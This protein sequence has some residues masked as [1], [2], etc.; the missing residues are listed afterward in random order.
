[1]TSLI[2]I[3]VLLINRLAVILSGLLAL[4]NLEFSLY[5][6]VEEY[7]N[8]HDFVKEEIEDV[9]GSEYPEEK[10]LDLLLKKID[11]LLSTERRGENITIKSIAI[12]EDLDR[13]ITYEECDN[14]LRISLKGLTKAITD[15]VLKVDALNTNM[16]ETGV[17]IHP[18]FL[19]SHA[20]VLYDWWTDRSFAIRNVH[21][22]LNSRLC[23]ILYFPAQFIDWSGETHLFEVHSLIVPECGKSEENGKGAEFHTTK[24]GFTPILDDD[25]LLEE[26]KIPT[27][28]MTYRI[29]EIPYVGVRVKEVKN[30]DG[31]EKRFDEAFRSACR[32]D[33]DVFYAA[34]MLCTEKMKSVTGGQSDYLKPL[35]RWARSEGLSVPRLIL[36]PTRWEDESNYLL[37]FDEN[38]TLLG[39][40]YKHIP[41]VDEKNGKV[42]A[43]NLSKA[44][45]S[46]YLIHLKNRQRIVIVICAEFLANPAYVR[47][48]LCGWL[49]ATLILV[50]SYSKGEQDFVTSLPIY[51]N[52]GANV[53]WGDCC[54]AVK[55]AK[56]EKRIIGGCSYAGT[57]K[58]NRFGDCV[59]CRFNCQG[60]Q[61]CLFEVELQTTIKQEKPGSPDAPNI[62]HYCHEV[63]ES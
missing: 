48:Y 25:T 16:K 53:I 32:H 13:R 58:I 29:N 49:G 59:D 63:T 39:K 15:E 1:M 3:K 30:P 44:P 12:V 45:N 17:F 41:Y 42:E 61:Y 10:R 60:T 40:Q 55:T 38:G 5:M 27:E 51:Q 26:E 28:Q 46:V 11:E 31:I 62:H 37:I 56:G 21:Q 50:P 4:K 14:P 24:I 43:L 9:L 22:G 2:D 52:Y 47:D 8:M 35:I 23:N 54:G 36:L 19:V 57:D 7:Q 34:E 6:A 33:L 18:K 20:R